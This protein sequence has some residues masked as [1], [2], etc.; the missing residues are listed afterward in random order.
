MTLRSNSGC[1]T[2]VKTRGWIE[3]R[4]RQGMV[5]LVKHKEYRRVS[6]VY[7]PIYH[8]IVIRRTYGRHEVC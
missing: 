6:T 3:S 7:I 4:G 8:E 5:Q 2:Q 1:N